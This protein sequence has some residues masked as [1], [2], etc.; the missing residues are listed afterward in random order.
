MLNNYKIIHKISLII[1]ST[2]KVE[3]IYKC[4]VYKYS[5]YYIR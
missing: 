2:N 3:K 1:T 4:T 5:K